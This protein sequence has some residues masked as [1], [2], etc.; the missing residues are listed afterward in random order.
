MPAG[1]IYS[2]PFDDNGDMWGV[3]LEKA[4]G[5][6]KGSIAISGAGCYVATGLRSLVGAPYYMYYAEESDI[7]EVF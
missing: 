1:L 7:D 3:I 4:W 6:V 2:A 5:K